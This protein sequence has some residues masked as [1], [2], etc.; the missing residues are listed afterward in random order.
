MAFCDLKPVRVIDVKSGLTY[1]IGEV[2]AVYGLGAQ[3]PVVYSWD[4]V[5]GV[6]INRRE[7]TFSFVGAKNNASILNKSFRSAEENLRAIAIIECQLR[8]YNFYYQHDKRL[9]PLKSLYV[10]CSP[11]KDSY[12]GE[13]MIDEADTAAAHIALLNF[14]LIKFLW[15]VAILIALVTFGIL[16][17]VIGLTRDNILY[18]ILIS[19]AAGGIFSLIVYI[20]T[21]ATARARVKSI[22]DADIASKETITYVVSTAGFAACESCIYQNRNLVSWSEAD[23][24]VE[25]DKMFIIFKGRTP[26]AYIPKKAFSKKSLSGVADIIAVSLEQK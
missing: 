2:F 7:M 6:S 5:K 16:D 18:F 21:H 3:F 24:F 1:V 19:I 15:L 20:I 25:S 22:A 8:I 23:Y 12:T 17:F 10:E 11:G 13:G 9:F 4:M 14:K 26:L